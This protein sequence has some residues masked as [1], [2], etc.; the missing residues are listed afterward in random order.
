MLFLIA[1]LL[2]LRAIEQSPHST[3]LPY[4]SLRIYLVKHGFGNMVIPGNT[5]LSTRPLITNRI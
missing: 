2:K 4:P 1:E 5:D 3:Y